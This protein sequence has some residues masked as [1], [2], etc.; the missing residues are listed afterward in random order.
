MIADNV[1][2]RKWYGNGNADQG[3]SPN[4][5]LATETGGRETNPDLYENDVLGRV[6]KRKQD[7]IW[8]RGKLKRT[9]HKEDE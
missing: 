3:G 4:G 2:E 6:V 7:D 5:G 1:S 9:K 8:S